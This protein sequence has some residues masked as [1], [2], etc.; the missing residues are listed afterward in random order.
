MKAL[1]TF[2]R[3]L[4]ILQDADGK[5]IVVVPSMALLQ[6]RLSLKWRNARYLRRV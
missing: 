5:K 2:T 6:P 1:T 4:S 3:Q